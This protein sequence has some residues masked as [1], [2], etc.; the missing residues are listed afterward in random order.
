MKTLFA[1]E[2]MTIPAGR[3]VSGTVICAGEI[4]V[5]AGRVWLTVEGEQADY[6]LCAGESVAVDAGRLVV[7]EADRTV[8]R[9]VFPAGAARRAAPRM[10]PV[11][12][13]N[14]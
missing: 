7:L 14:C 13:F 1:G 2:M 8:C 6:W 9:V 11:S 5:V 3:A 10:R 12:L 4:A